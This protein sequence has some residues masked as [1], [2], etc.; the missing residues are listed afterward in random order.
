MAIKVIDESE[1]VVSRRG[2]TATYDQELLKAL[3]SLKAGKALDVTEH[4]GGPFKETADR[5]RVAQEI[6]K[7]WKATGRADKCRIDFGAGRAQV[8][9]KK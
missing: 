8:R 2:R 9:V 6:R 5:Q 1:V 7:H 3:G 4:M